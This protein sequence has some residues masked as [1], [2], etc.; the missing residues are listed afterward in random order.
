M[1]RN[2]DRGY[3]LNVIASYAQ[4]GASTIYGIFGPSIASREWGIN[5]YGVWLYFF[6]LLGYLQLVGGLGL[7]N[8]TYVLIGR[9]TGRS[10]RKAVLVGGT[11]ILGGVG[12]VLGALSILSFL[13][14][15]AWTFSLAKFTDNQFHS[16]ISTSKVILF[17][18]AFSLPLIS[19]GGAL[20]GIN[21]QYIRSF[22]DALSSLL[23]LGALL[24]LATQG[25][26]V[27]EFACL[28]CLLQVLLLLARW[29]IA[30]ILIQKEP[31]ERFDFSYASLLTTGGWSLLMAS[32]TM[33]L[34]AIDVVLGGKMIPMASFALYLLV[35]RLANMAF[36]IPMSMNNS[37]AGKL[38]ELHA[39]DKISE[40]FRIK[41]IFEKRC[42][43][44]AG[45]V[46][47]GLILWSIPFVKIWLGKDQ[48]PSIWLMSSLS[49]YGFFYI[50]TNILTVVLNS[51]GDVRGIGLVSAMEALVKLLVSFALIPRFGVMSF[52]IAGIISSA[53]LPNLF[54][55]RRVNF[56]KARW[57][58]MT[59]LVR[60][61]SILV[62]LS[63]AL[64]TLLVHTFGYWGSL[65]GT[66]ITLLFCW[67]GYQTIFNETATNAYI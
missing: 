60:T 57:T 55:D 36:F 32:T 44:L 11:K 65:I 30:F 37:L 54:L 10:Y 29:I 5:E 4:L 67:W 27:V 59:W 9:H 24:F 31:V 23:N 62:L 49:V 45:L 26:S 7:D 51:K 64:C 19:A 3:R 33:S 40:I 17:Y 61:E 1:N 46:G 50:R 35:N 20:T 66:P 48:A 21:R 63:F 41:E 12:L 15:P 14:T 25:R 53:L 43:V 38:S 42:L 18:F 6:G 16:A 34:Q 52:P 22:G 2:A 28:S 47:S 39:S 56:G 13:I 8:A 58:P